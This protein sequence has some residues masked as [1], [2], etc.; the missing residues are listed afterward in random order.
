[1][2][3]VI[4]NLQ[5]NLHRI[6]FWACIY[7]I[8]YVRL[9][10]ILVYEHYVCGKGFRFNFFSNLKQDQQ[11]IKSWNISE[12]NWQLPYVKS[13]IKGFSTFRLFLPRISSPPM[14]F[15]YLGQQIVSRKWLTFLF[16]FFNF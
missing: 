3:T 10:Y 13:K 7:S 9:S 11:N 15:N 14:A 5:Q 8:F 2:V 12:S 1:M 16:F 4:D 6:G